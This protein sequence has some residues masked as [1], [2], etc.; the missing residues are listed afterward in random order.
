M[1]ENKITITNDKGRLSKEDVEKMTADAEKYRKEDEEWKAKIESRNGLEQ[2]AYQMK[3]QIEDE[4]NKDKLEAADA[5]AVK[6]ACQE[7]L[8]WL[9]SNQSA[10]KEE[11]EHRMSELKRVC[12]P[13][14]QKMYGAGGGMPGGVPGGCLVECQEECLGHH[15]LHPVDLVDQASKKWIK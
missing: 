10:E 3:G 11:Y 4:K 2:Y 15:L 1:G 9:E 6:N 8:T 13:I 12:D 5:D 14:L 7:C